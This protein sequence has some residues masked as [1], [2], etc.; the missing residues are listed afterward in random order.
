MIDPA[1]GPPR[2]LSLSLSLSY[3]G[4]MK[5]QSGYSM[6]GK[7]SQGPIMCSGRKQQDDK[8]SKHKQDVDQDR[9]HDGERTNVQII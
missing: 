6:I 1:V 2:V 9:D 4:L 3:L 8:G 5:S 7:L